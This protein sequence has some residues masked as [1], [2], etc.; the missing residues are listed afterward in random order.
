MQRS[1]ARD[2]TLQALLV[3]LSALGS[4]IKLGFYSVAFDSTAGFVAALLLG[5]GV[6]ALGGWIARRWGLTAGLTAELLPEP[7]REGWDL[8]RSAGP[9]T[10]LLAALSPA[11]LPG[12]GL[13]CDRPWCPIAVLHHA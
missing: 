11:A 10:V 13:I 5:P 1:L 4:L 6:G 8:T 12:F 7:E 9:A 3:A 2:L